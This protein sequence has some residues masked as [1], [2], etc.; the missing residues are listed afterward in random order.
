MIFSAIRKSK[1]RIISIPEGYFN[2]G[3]EVPVPGTRV[4]IRRLSIGEMT[5]SHDDARMYEEE[6]TKAYN[7]ALMLNIVAKSL[8]MPDDIT[9]PLLKAGDLEARM[10]FTSEGLV[11]LYDIVLQMHLSTS[12]LYEEITDPQI[13]LLIN[14]LKTHKVNKKIRRLLSYV[15][16]CLSESE[17]CL[18]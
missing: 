15:L 18:Y 5:D 10:A 17:L 16:D 2:E 12:P 9:K 8:V 14:L 6:G 1:P 13:E 11:Y 7:Q 4:G 3:Y